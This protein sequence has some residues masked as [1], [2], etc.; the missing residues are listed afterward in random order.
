MAQFDSQ[1]AFAQAQM[2]ALN[3][4]DNSVKSVA[5]AISAMNQSVIA[6]LSVTGGKGTT[7][8]PTNN[9]A[10]ID[11]IYKELLGRKDGADAAGKDYWLGE[12]ANGHIGLDQLTQAIANAARENK[13]KVKAGYATGGLISGPGSG[14]SDSI[15]ARL[16]NG[17]YVLTADA[18][19]TYGTDLLDQMNGRKL[20]AFAGGGI[21]GSGAK[22]A[23]PTR[24]YSVTQ[25]AATPSGSGDSAAT[26]AELRQL[27]ADIHN[28]LAFL[29]KH[30]EKTAYNTTQINES[31]VQVV[32]TVKTEAV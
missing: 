6:A 22:S 23:T 7:N 14:T 12:L 26:I 27:R 13:E 4:I 1:L 21:A 11:T 9:G 24:V 17:E 30:M 18:V 20:P 32:N 31:G 10:Y 25:T 8:T 29:T 15:V 16:S 5:D 28:D 19:R 3:G 2:D